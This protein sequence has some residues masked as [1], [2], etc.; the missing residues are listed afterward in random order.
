VGAGREA[1][2]GHDLTMAETG[3]RVE[4][5][6]KV[7]RDL[8]SLGLDVDDL[9]DAFS[10]IATEAA[11]VVE[12]HTP[13]K[14]GRLAG[15][16]RGNRAQSKAVVSIGRASVPY[17][18][19]INYGWPKRNIK[20]ANFIAKTDEEMQPQALRLLEDEIN[21]AIRRRGLQ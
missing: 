21:N 9:K 17:A 11:Q 13:K 5:L 20:P 7:V 16:V 6:Q 8:K 2:Q 1:D 4:G 12:S 14:S 19:P 3:V 10:R 18:G 15:S